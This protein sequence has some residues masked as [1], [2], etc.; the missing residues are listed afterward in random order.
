MTFRTTFKDG[1]SPYVTVITDN[2]LLTITSDS[3]SLD[4][5]EPIL[6]LESRDLAVGKLGQE[7]WFLII[8]HMHIVSWN[9]DLEASQGAN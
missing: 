6:A 8:G 1:S 5:L 4:E 7:L 3:D 9:N 2:P